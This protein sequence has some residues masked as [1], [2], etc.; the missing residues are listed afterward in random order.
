MFCFGYFVC[1]L[2]QSLKELKRKSAENSSNK[3]KMSFMNVFFRAAFSTV[4]DLQRLYSKKNMMYGTLCR[5]LTITHLISYTVEKGE[6][7]SR[8]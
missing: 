1:I 5:R 4:R 3:Q 2:L 8:T 7:F 6:Q